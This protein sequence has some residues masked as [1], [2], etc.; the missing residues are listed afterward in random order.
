MS[1]VVKK[2][3]K[4]KEPWYDTAIDLSKVLSLLE[5]GTLLIGGKPV[6]DQQLIQLK[7][8]AQVIERLPAWGILIETMRQYA[9]S[10]GFNSSLD[11]ES[12]KVAKAMLLILDSQRAWARRLATA[13][14]L[15]RKT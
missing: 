7:A 5:D 15:I 13:Q 12:V 11:F 9:I 14:P 8:D 6:P 10:A 3:R 1:E 2:P 4:M